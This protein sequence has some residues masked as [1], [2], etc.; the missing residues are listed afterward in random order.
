[1]Y[2]KYFKRPLDFI[3]SVT[4]LIL[5]SPVLLLLTVFNAIAMKG[6]PFF[7]QQRPGRKGKDGKDL[8]KNETRNKK[9]IRMEILKNLSFIL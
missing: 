1:M 4:A 8:N 5:L 9:K 2:A 6:N 3:L 7:V